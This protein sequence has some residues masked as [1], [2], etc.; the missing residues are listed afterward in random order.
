MPLL[1]YLPLIIWTGLFE[2]AGQ[3]AVPVKVKA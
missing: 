2:V 1:S 3:N